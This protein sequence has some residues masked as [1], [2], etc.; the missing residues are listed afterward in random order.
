MIIIKMLSS[1]VY[2][3]GL[4]FSTF[5]PNIAMLVGAIILST[6]IVCIRINTHPYIIINKH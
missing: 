6:L 3:G 1:Y 2:I 4:Q 5:S